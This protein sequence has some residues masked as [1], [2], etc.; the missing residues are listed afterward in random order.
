M[1]PSGLVILLPITTPPQQS[2][3]PSAP[4]G[5]SLLSDLMA[6]LRRRNRDAEA[7]KRRALA[8]AADATRLA[9]VAERRR[10]NAIA[11][12]RQEG[13]TEEELAAATEHTTPDRN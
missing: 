7:R 2:V 10:R 5:R 11:Y 9:R 3:P 6:P 8:L 12:A 4:S 13:A 1:H